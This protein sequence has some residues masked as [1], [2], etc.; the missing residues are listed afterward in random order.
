[1]GR[2]E[3]EVEKKFCNF[4]IESCTNDFLNK[5]SEQIREYIK[6]YNEI[7]TELINK[8][9]AELTNKKKKK[10]TPEEAIKVLQ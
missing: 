4:S 9:L 10:V 6:K 1:M 3:M 2:Y 7:L 5:N 8:N